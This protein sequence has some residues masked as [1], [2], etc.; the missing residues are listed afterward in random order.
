MGDHSER[1]STHLYPVLLSSYTAAFQA[2]LPVKNE[3]K[4][5]VFCTELSELNSM[6]RVLLSDVIGIGSVDPQYM[7]FNT[8]SGPVP[9]VIFTESYSQF[10]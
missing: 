4:K 9:L 1:S 10:C 3:A 5:P 7:P 8:A 2:N 6:V